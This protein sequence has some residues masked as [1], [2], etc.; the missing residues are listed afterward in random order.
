MFLFV[1]N[2]FSNFNAI[3]V[4]DIDANRFVTLQKGIHLHN[5]APLAMH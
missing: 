3:I 2:P 1:L 5:I 4:F